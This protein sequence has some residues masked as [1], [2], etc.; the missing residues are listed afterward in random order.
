[1]MDELVRFVDVTGVMPEFEDWAGRIDLIP[2]RRAG[3]EIC[4]AVI[5]DDDGRGVVSARFV[6]HGCE[7]GVDVDVVKAHLLKERGAAGLKTMAGVRWT[8][9]IKRQGFGYMFASQNLKVTSK[10][11]G[12]RLESQR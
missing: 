7:V 8:G 6:H 2:A 12:V 1:M 10:E 3:A 4:R 11:A 9:L 5:E